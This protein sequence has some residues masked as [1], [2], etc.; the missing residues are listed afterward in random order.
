MEALL[1]DS[2]IS[3]AV[4]NPGS[5]STF[6]SGFIALGATWVS[7]HYPFTVPLTRNFELQVTNEI[8]KIRSL[9]ARDSTLFVVEEL[10]V[11]FSQHHTRVSQV[12][13]QALALA[14][15]KVIMDGT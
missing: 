12:R 4:N 2:E 6:E 1:F 9:M 14:L 11:I 8:N 5:F 3:L 7:I 10:F 15:Q 13:T